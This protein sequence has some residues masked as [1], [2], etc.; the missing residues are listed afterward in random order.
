MQVKEFTY[1]KKDGSESA[2]TVMVTRQPSNMVMGIDLSEL[3]KDD[4]TAYVAGYSTLMDA[5]MAQVAELDASFDT[6]HRIRQFDPTKML[7]VSD[8]WIGNNG[9]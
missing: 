3:D 5:F 2:R 6:K 7:N 8:T 9:S 1:V 4:A